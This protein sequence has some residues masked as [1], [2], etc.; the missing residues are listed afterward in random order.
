MEVEGMGILDVGGITETSGGE[1]CGVTFIVGRGVFL[2]EFFL[3][4]QWL[5]ED[6]DD[7][8]QGSL[9]VDGG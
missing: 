3:R 7:I 2:F 1:G 6:V 8:V 9:C 5:G 4:F